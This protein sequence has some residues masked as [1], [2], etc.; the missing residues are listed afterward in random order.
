VLR[1]RDVRLNE[2]AAVVRTDRLSLQFRAQGEEEVQVDVEAIELRSTYDDPDGRAFAAA[3]LDVA[4]IYRDG[5]ALRAPGWVETSLHA[6]SGDRLLFSLASIGTASALHVE[7]ALG[8]QRR[9]IECP[10]G[11]GWTDVVLPFDELGVQGDTKLRFTLESSANPRAVLLIGSIVQVAPAQERLPDVVLYLEDTLRPDHL[12]TYGWSSPTDP[13]LRQVAAAGAVFERTFS[14]SN[15]TRPAVSSLM[16]SLIP[17]RHGNIQLEYRVPESLTLLAEALAAQGYLTVS[18]V[19]NFHGGAW[20]GLDQGFD[21]IAEPGAWDVPA[22]TSTLTSRVLTPTLQE[23][24]AHYQG[25]RLFVYAHSLDPHAPYEP[26]PELLDALAPSE[27]P[28]PATASADE[29]SVHDES[30]HYDGEILHNDGQLEALDAALAATGRQADTLLVFVS[31]HGESFGDYTRPTER[32]GHRHHQ[33]LRQS[34][35]MIPLVLRWPGRID[36]G[37][38]FDRPVSLID[39]APTILGLLGL[40]RPAAWAGEDLAP[41]LTEGARPSDRREPI[42]LDT[43]YMPRVR[44]LFGVVRE[45]AVVSWPYKLIARVEAGSVRAGELYDLQA[46]PT[47]ARNLVDDP[48]RAALLAELIERA[49]DVVA[50]GAPP[51]PASAA[52]PADPDTQEWL[53]AMGY[54][55]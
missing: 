20:S 37:Q 44:D 15:W 43:T 8:D 18:L 22:I 1:L 41:L 45:V 6:G 7:V 9:S 29:L 17:S 2:K 55:R 27:V 51:D 25:V 30:R 28:P 40:P 13:H 26:P 52:V 21:V 12:S 53:R 5:L 31:D 10:P 46:D 14:T 50:S 32:G 42:V 11:Q 34:E 33:T 38:R 54:V 24:L 4:E 3:K 49:T 16:T 39:V 35:V 36:A 19:T 48:A 47:E 23:L